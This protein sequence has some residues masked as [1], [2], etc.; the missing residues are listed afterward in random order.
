MARII[1][2]NNTFT[3]RGDGSKYRI[4]NIPYQ[5]FS[6][7]VMFYR[8]MNPMFEHNIHLNVQENSQVNNKVSERS[9]E[10]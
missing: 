4:K 7:K 8:S 9:R 5:K 3:S 6:S 10:V 2:T 1:D